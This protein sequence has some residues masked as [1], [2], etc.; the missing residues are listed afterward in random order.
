MGNV[1]SRE[2]RSKR[3]T[4]SVFDS[5]IEFVF[6]VFRSANSIW[7]S[8]STALPYLFS[9]NAGDLRKEVTEQYPDPVSSRTADELPP[10]TRGILFNDIE[11]CTGCGD[12]QRSCPVQCMVVE[13]E[14]VPETSKTWVSVFD[15]DFSRCAFCGICV[16][17]CHPRS[18]SHTRQYEGAVS[19]AP[20]LVA[21]FGKGRVTQEQRQKWAI[22]REMT[23][24]GDLGI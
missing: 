23:R 19:L 20:D 10:R 5:T 6:L 7:R 24:P 9:K 16:E 12:C 13:V 1:S 8:F 3:Q 21:H 11:S 22:A 2:M 17:V 4:A 15:I 14:Q 18:L